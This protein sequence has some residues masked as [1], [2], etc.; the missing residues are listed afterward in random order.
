MNALITSNLEDT[1]YLEEKSETS[2]KNDKM[3]KTTYGLIRTHDIKYYVLYE[4]F[5]RKMWEILEKSI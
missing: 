2:K 1:L 5:A 3:N 4:T